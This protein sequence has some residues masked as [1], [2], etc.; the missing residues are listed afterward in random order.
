[1]KVAGV[2]GHYEKSKGAYSSYFEMNEFDFYKEVSKHLKGVDIYEHNPEIRN[3]RSRVRNTAIN[4]L[5]PKDY[6]LVMEFHFNSFDKE[7]SGCETVYFEKSAKGYAH[8][9]RFSEL[10]HD[11]TGIPL[12][13][14]NGLKPVL[15]RFERGQ[16]SVYY[17]KAPAILIEPFFGDN[18]EDCAKIMSPEHLA[19][20][21]Q[22]FVDTM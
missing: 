17:P 1:M 12:R 16:A 18:I 22:E 5:D 21:I 9:K 2:I 15:T 3:Y 10:V 20:I 4:K 7:T 11:C 14:S 19:Q 8:A 13:R 6:D